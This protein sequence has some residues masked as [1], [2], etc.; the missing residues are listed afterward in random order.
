MLVNAIWLIVLRNFTTVLA[1]SL[2][3]TNTVRCPNTKCIMCSPRGASQCGSD[4]W[5][6]SS[7]RSRKWKICVGSVTVNGCSHVQGSVLHVDGGGGP[8]I[9]LS[10]R[11]AVDTAASTRR[12]VY[13]IFL[14]I[15]VIFEPTERHLGRFNIFLVNRVGYGTLYCITGVEAFAAWCETNGE[16]IRFT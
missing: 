14:F 10:V 9:M 8:I 4:G 16:T 5:F 1:R 11:V 6:P 2:I 15:I 12:R 7:R 3:R 13:Y